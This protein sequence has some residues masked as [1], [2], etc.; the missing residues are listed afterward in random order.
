[1]HNA[2]MLPFMKEI[3]EIL[4]ADGYLK[5]VFATTTFAI[6]LN[7]PARSVLFTKV[8]KFNGGDTDE[9]IQTSEYLQMAGRAGR[10]GKD[11]TGSCLICLDKSFGRQIPTLDDFERLLENKGTPLE[12]KLKLSYAMTMNVMKSDSIM[13]E[14]MLKVSWFE[15]ESEKDRID[16]TKKAN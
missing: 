11:A 9:L 3:V 14:D 6:G 7:M 8:Y 12:S 5:V 10:R 1:M 13:I 4:F 2:G 15:S 16:A